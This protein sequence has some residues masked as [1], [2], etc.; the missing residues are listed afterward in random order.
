MRFGASYQ[1]S[2]VSFLSAPRIATLGPLALGY[3]CRSQQR[4]RTTGDRFLAVFDDVPCLSDVNKRSFEHL[5]FSFGS[6]P[7]AAL[8]TKKKLQSD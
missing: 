8:A 5:Y 3:L 6:V 7:A 1:P 2:A 4:R